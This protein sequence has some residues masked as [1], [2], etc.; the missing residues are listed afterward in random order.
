MVF[1]ADWFNKLKPVST[2]VWDINNS[3]INFHQKYLGVVDTIYKIDTM[4]KIKKKLVDWLLLLKFGVDLKE[5]IIKYHGYQTPP[6]INFNL[7]PNTGNEYYASQITISMNS[8]KLRQI[9]YL[10]SLINDLIIQ[11]KSDIVYLESKLREIVNQEHNTETISQ[12]LKNIELGEI[13]V[14]LD[15]SMLVI[16]LIVG[17]FTIVGTFLAAYLGAKL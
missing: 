10:I 8:L 12:G 7:R 14:Q 4:A 9:E 11:I 17:A 1:N 2:E 6:N 16:A 5:T 3:L 15:K 13:S